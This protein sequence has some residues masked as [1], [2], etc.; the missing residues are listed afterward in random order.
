MNGNY[1]GAGSGITL[2]LCFGAAL[3]VATQN[4]AVGVAIGVGLGVA[5]ATGFGAESHV[6]SAR[7]KAVADT[8]LPHPLGLFEREHHRTN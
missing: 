6:A 2:G 5:F 7:K 4:V 8:P 1:A 3:G